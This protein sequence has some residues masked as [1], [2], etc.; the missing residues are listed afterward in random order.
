VEWSQD[1]EKNQQHTGESKDKALN[2]D[3]CHDEVIELRD[4]PDGEL[5]RVSVD[6][7]EVEGLEVVNVET[8]C[9]RSWI[10]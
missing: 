8:P 5:S 9:W 10:G 4:I 3:C 2:C 1:G 6:V 7:G